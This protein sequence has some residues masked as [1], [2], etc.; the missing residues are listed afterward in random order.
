ML[1]PQRGIAALECTGR[2]L[3]APILLGHQALLTSSFSWFGERWLSAA[4]IFAVLALVTVCLV[5]EPLR[6]GIC[7]ED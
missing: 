2:F 6:G 4:P 5:A 1:R 7:L 3:C